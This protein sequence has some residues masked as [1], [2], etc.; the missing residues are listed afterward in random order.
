MKNMSQIATFIF[1][2]FAGIQSLAIAPLC[3]D[4]FEGTTNS[5]YSIHQKIDAAQSPEQLLATLQ[6]IKSISEQGTK[7]NSYIT[8]INTTNFDAQSGK[9]VYSGILAIYDIQTVVSS[10]DKK[11]SEPITLAKMKS[12]TRSFYQKHSEINFDAI[13]DFKSFS[14]LGEHLYEM[15]FKLRKFDVIM[16]DD[17][18][19]ASHKIT[20]TPLVFKNLQK[21]KK[22]TL[23][24][25]DKSNKLTPK[26]MVS[27]LS[28]KEVKNNVETLFFQTPKS[29]SELIQ[30]YL[31][32]IAIHPYADGNGRMSRLFY[33]VQSAKMLKS[34]NQFLQVDLPIYD[35]DLFLNNKDFQSMQTVHRE[36]KTWIVEAP[37]DADFINRCRWALYFIKQLYPEYVPG[38]GATNE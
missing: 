30:N 34:E 10:A 13:T 3:S 26:A 22:L 19:T 27:Y 29:E 23:E 21:Q 31:N 16:T 8:P 12:A 11:L 18:P 38:Q 6:I 7:A 14:A 24:E 37:D 35:W 33:E 2:I 15:K 36:L 32:F 4:I 20:M 25:I 5:A 17:G 1:I 28:Y 9:H